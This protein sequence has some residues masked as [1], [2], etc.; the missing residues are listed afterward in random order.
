METQLLR[1]CGDTAKVSSLSLLQISTKSTQL[2]A[3]VKKIP[4]LLIEPKTNKIQKVLKP[5]I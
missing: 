1:F 5:Y 2:I 3:A 4:K